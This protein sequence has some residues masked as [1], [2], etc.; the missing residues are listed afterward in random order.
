MKKLFVLFAMILSVFSGTTGTVFAD[1]SGSNVF[2][3]SFKV[4]YFETGFMPMYSAKGSNEGGIFEELLQE[5]G[6]LTNDDFEIVYYPATRLYNFF[7]D[8]KIDIDVVACPEW[9]PGE[10]N[11]SVYTKPVISFSEAVFVRKGKSLMVETVNDLRG[12]TVG[13]VKGYIY[14]GWSENDIYKPEFATKEETLFRKFKEGRY[15]VLI[16][17]V[18][19]AKYYASKYGLELEVAKV[20]YTV[21]LGMRI[22]VNKGTAID[23]INGALDQLKKDGKVDFIVQKYLGSSAENI[24]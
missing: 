3:D 2:A 23:R 14:P 1:E 9:F 22:H 6:K 19:V 11:F 15:D 18:P 7:R 24:N 16:C 12:E 13:I 21:D 8:G 10:D 17:A 20:M 5:I 4:G